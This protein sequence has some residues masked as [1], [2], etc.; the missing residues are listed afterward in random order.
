MMWWMN[1]VLNPLMRWILSG[2]LHGWMDKGVMLISFQGRKSKKFYTTPVQY[3][4]AGQEIWVT[5]GMPEKKR[6]WWNLVGGGLVNVCLRGEWLSGD[7]LVL[8]GEDDREEIRRGLS[9]KLKQFPQ[10]AHYLPDPQKS[11][12]MVG[13][14]V[15]VK[16]MLH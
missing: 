16:V 11:D 13:D 3:V 6:W 1:H 2:P 14:V 4:Q 12:F 7:A 8:R 10:S 9:E 5:V 15:M